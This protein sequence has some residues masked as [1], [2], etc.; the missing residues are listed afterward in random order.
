MRASIYA[1]YSSDNQRETSVEDQ[2]RNGDLRAEREGWPTPLHFSDRE[3]SASIPTHLRPGGRLLMEAIRAG[4]IDVLIIEALDR[5]WRDIVDQEQV[6]REIEARGIRIIGLFDGYDSEREGRE[7]QRVI[8]GGVN[9]QY[10]RDLG[11]K[12]HRGLTGQVDRGLYAGGLA[13]GYRSVVIGVDAKGNPLGSR[14]E[15]DQDQ[16][17]HVRWVYEQYAEGLGIPAIVNDL[18][19]RRVPSPRGGTWVV[20]GLYGSP[21]K[22]TGILNNELYTGRYTWNRSKWVKD[23]QGVRKRIERP[24]AEWKTSDRQELRIVPDDLWR[25]VR[26]RLATPI[27]EGGSKGRGKRPVSLLGGL[28]RCGICGGPV[29]VTTRDSY[30]CSVS[31]NRGVSV[32]AG[33]SVYREVA[34]T[35]LMAYLRETLL[36]PAAVAKLQALVRDQIKLQ[37]RT[38]ESTRH[39][40]GTRRL[41]LKREIDNLTAAIATMGLSMALADRL[42]AA[43]AELS[44]MNAPEPDHSAV[45]RAIPDVM[46]KYRRLLADLPGTLKREPERARKAIADM[47][48]RV[49]LIQEGE[50]IYAEMESTPGA[51]LL[52]SGIDVTRIGSGGAVSEVITTKR[53][54]LR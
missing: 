15:I 6:I 47:L 24:R 21:A 16:A 2:L 35:R 49:R 8:I 46:A 30:G 20:S 13:Y 40:S 33:L 45:L 25:A 22:G 14:L 34:E 53:I 11:K 44:A 52:A 5:C 38:A 29:T 3:V 23:T 12:V 54:K 10:L 9:Q 51:L 17:A 31:K 39:S 37:A 7:L 50:E 27:I 43:E 4:T 36:A 26:A 42:R 18:N 48:G 28:M 1:R 41:E 32:C 19:S